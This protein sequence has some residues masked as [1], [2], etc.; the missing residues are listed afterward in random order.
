MNERLQDAS[1]GNRHFDIKTSDGFLSVYGWTQRAWGIRSITDEK[2]S[3]H[4]ITHLP[5]GHRLGFYWVDDE[6]DHAKQF[7]EN[8]NAFLEE[9][10]IDAWEEDKDRL[11]ELLLPV[12]EEIHGIAYLLNCGRWL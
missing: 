5:T 6:H 7:I 2:G 4:G 11:L 1:E 9:R 10:G 12:K 3:I 8:L